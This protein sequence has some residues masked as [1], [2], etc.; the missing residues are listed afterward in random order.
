[1]AMSP[2]MLR[3][4]SRQ[5][6]LTD[7]LPTVV[8]DE[9]RSNDRRGLVRTVALALTCLV[10]TESVLSHLKKPPRKE[11]PLLEG[12]ER[13]FFETIDTEEC[14]ARITLAFFAVGRR[15]VTKAGRS[16][17]SA[18]RAG[19]VETLLVTD[20][21]REC[22][23]DVVLSVSNNETREFAS[24][25]AFKGN[26]LEKRKKSDEESIARLRAAKIKALGLAL[27]RAT[28]DAL[29]F[30]DA[31]TLVCRSLLP[32]VCGVL[33]R[34]KDVGFV[35]LG[36]DKWHATKQLKALYKVSR[37]T[38]EAG[39]GALVFSRFNNDTRRAT[40]L[41]ETWRQVYDELRVATPPQ[42]SDRVAF[43][44][45]LHLSKV[46][47]ALLN[48]AFHCQGA[49]SKTHAALG[50]DG[51]PP[52][53][54]ADEDPDKL[55]DSLDGGRHCDILHSQDLTTARGPFGNHSTPNVE[56]D[57]IDYWIDV[58]FASGDAP[59]IRDAFRSAIKDARTKM[60]HDT[61]S[62]LPDF[63]CPVSSLVTK[64]RRLHNTTLSP[65]AFIV[66]EP[67]ERV[68]REYAACCQGPLTADTE[69][70][71]DAMPLCPTDQ[72]DLG[73]AITQF[74]EE[75]GDVLV[76]TLFSLL[77]DADSPSCS[78]VLTVS[79]ADERVVAWRVA[80]EVSLVGAAEKPRETVEVALRGSSRRRRRRD[81]TIPPPR[82][83]L[84]AELSNEH[85]ARIRRALA[86]DRHIH[87]VA[88]ARFQGEL[89]ALRN[90][91]DDTIDRNGDPSRS[92]RLAKPM[93]HMSVQNYFRRRR[94]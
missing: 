37:S 31:D 22:D 21:P 50:C 35:A 81:V 90:H 52:P 39:T 71:A 23:F 46:D 53:L 84:R 80:T 41:V 30:V 36:R 13:V 57:C 70:C 45:A 19:N 27:R 67:V 55:E 14:E 44:A 94:R 58:P 78:D 66:R 5:A 83:P 38:P 40:R 4:R 75:R 16:A 24:F 29:V 54:L 59:E 87:K 32:R 85:L 73:E 72:R 86:L 28:G 10:A 68:L 89:D 76:A 8:R 2:S 42:L 15:A 20:A 92:A 26:S 74:A 88:T 33:N 17:A 56:S 12:Q 43:R 61:R 60:I 91:E 7:E 79:R 11:D 18:K 9:I 47:F 82:S 93:K 34:G 63:E 62:V 3:S 25:R 48:P 64:T 6:R 51:L 49:T 69:W 65:A 77:Y 1:M